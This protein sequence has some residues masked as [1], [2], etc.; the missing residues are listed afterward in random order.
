MATQPIY[1]LSTATLPAELIEEAAAKGIALDTMDFIAIEPVI[2][3]EMGARIRE[4]GRQ[5]L[6]AVFTSTNAVEAIGR[7]GGR[8]W[9]IFCTSGATR[10]LVA[11]RFGADTIAGTADSAAGL[12]AQI[13]RVAP[14]DAAA[15]VRRAAVY[16]FCGDQRRDELPDLLKEVGLTVHEVVV[17][18]TLLTPRKTE[19]VYAGIA[20]F[21][22]SAVESYFSLNTVADDVTL[23]AIGRTTAA[24]IQARCS[25]LVIISDR[26]GKEALVRTMTDYFQTNNKE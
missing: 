5:P 2:D 25:H 15:E 22:P 24:A 9:M 11:E 16:F 4:L 17:Y 7:T 23:F 8:D 18:R 13:I 21:S 12:A 6:V 1:L 20:F 3:A 19:R 14:S 26:P 10:Q